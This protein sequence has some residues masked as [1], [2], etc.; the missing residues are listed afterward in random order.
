MDQGRNNHLSEREMDV[1]LVD[2]SELSQ[3]AREHLAH[4]PECRARVELLSA[5]L[6]TLG[7]LAREYSPRA[8]NRFAVPEKKVRQGSLFGRHMALAGGGAL[9]LAFLAV[10]GLNVWGPGVG[11]NQGRT[12]STGQLELS[13]VRAELVEVDPISPFHSF[14]M[15][16]STAVVNDEFLK[17]VSEPVEN[18]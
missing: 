18:I 12:V 16:Q 14:V 11:L 8:R 5:K 1:A 13:S 15:G 4:C 6:N 3:E 10:L 9:A 17:F 2:R 7:R